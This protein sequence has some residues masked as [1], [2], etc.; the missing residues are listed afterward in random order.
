[1]G[2][3]LRLQQVTIGSLPD[4]VLLKVFYFHLVPINKWEKEDLRASDPWRWHKLVHVCRRWRCIVFDAPRRLDL[5]LYC[6]ENTPVRKLL[7]IWPELPLVIHY[8]E[9]FFLPLDGKI[10]Q[11]HRRPGTS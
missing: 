11:R 10:G 5:E 3:D 7:H 9:T 2:A 6:T 1:V 4:E 8:Y